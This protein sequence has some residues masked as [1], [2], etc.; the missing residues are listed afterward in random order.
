MMEGNRAF[1]LMLAPA[2]E[3]LEGRDP[4]EIARMSGA[5]YDAGSS[6]L[7]LTS[8]GQAFEIHWPDCR[9]SPDVD[10]WW[11]LVMLHYLHGAS[12]AGVHGELMNFAALPGGLA[13]GGNYDRQSA[14]ELG[15]MLGELPIERVEAACRAMGARIVDSNADVCAEFDFLPRYPMT[16]KLW[17]AEDDIPASARLMLD[18]SAASYLSVEDAVTAG[19]ILIERLRAQLGAN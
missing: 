3:W 9:V 7:R 18:A 11:Q 17:L 19:T 1:E 6:A 13:R 4:E 10:A 16:V 14:N 5:V 2:R 8:L 15:A 12:G